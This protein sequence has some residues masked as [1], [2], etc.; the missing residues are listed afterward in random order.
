MV[1]FK[2]SQLTAFLKSPDPRMRAMLLYGPDSAQV[3]DHAAA[4]AKRL[5][6]VCEQDG[7]M[8]RLGDRDLSDEPGRLTTE[9]RTVSMFS[10]MKVIHVSAGKHFPVADMESLLASEL[11]SWIVVE[12]GNLRPTAKLRKIFEASK[13]AAALPCYELNTRDMTTFV[14][15][16]LGELGV[17]IVPE[18]RQ[19][20]VSLFAGNQARARA[21]IAKL[22]LYTGEGGRAEMAD[23]DAVIGDVA[24]AAFD[25]LTTAVCSGKPKEA[26]SQLDRF[27]AGGQGV[28]GAIAALER[29]FHKLHR[30]CCALESGDAMRSALASFRPPLHFRQ[31]D[32]LEAQTRNWSRARSAKAIDLIAKVALSARQRPELDQIYAERLV[33]VLSRR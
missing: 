31:R 7:E 2:A 10:A 14:D 33:L 26:L 30:V 21:E 12:A 25:D 24:Q 22:A 32:A 5:L 20:L 18:A 13:Q 29:H 4:L 11:D 19:Q 9:A 16:E 15:T 17:T 27:G 3:G 8:I 1:A 23:V 6:S 28:Q